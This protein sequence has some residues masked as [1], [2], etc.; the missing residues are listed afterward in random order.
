MPIHTDWVSMIRGMAKTYAGQGKIKCRDVVGGKKV[1]ASEKA[2]DVFF[3]TGNKKYG[4]GFE[5][6]P[7]RTKA[8]EAL[9]LEWFMERWKRSV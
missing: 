4:E 8:E 5:T 2:W 9:I 3:G 1:C 7:R 6:K